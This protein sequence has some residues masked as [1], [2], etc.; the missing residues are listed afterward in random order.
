MFGEL[1]LMGADTQKYLVFLSYFNQDGTV[2]TDVGKS[3]DTE[4]H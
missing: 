2:R 3:T 4:F 1:H